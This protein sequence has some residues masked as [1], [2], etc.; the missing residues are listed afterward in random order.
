MSVLQ[1]TLLVCHKPPPSLMLPNGKKGGS[2]ASACRFASNR[3][4]RKECGNKLCRD[5]WGRNDRSEK[6]IGVYRAIQ[7][8]P[9]LQALGEPTV[10]LETRR[11]LPR[12]MLAGLSPTQNL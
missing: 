5:I 9:N 6:H 2:A 4:L 3:C 11:G 8:R 7:R 10:D 1:T 12:R